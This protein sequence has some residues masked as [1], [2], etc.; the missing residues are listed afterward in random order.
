M[1][2]MKR[3]KYILIFI[4]FVNILIYSQEDF[5]NDYLNEESYDLEMSGGGLTIYGERRETKDVYVLEKLSGS[6]SDRKQFIEIDFLEGAGFKRSGNVKIRKSDGSEKA[7]SVLHGIGHL[8]SFGIIPVKPFSDIEYDRLPKGDFYK[9]EPVFIKSNFTN[10]TPEVLIIMELEYILQIEYCNGILTQDNVK[11][12]SGESINKF[13]GLIEKLPEYS[14]SIV[15]IR[16]RFLIDLKKIK[17]SF[18]RFKN[19]SENYLRAIENLGDGF[20]MN[21]NK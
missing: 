7:Y 2:S 6:L 10:V 4:F 20:N 11:Y 5:E 8:L 19:P 13:Q 3:E 9:F 15:Y 18:E 16:N 21:R 1:V 17:A 14:E 12:Y